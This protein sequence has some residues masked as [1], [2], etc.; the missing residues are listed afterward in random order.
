LKTLKPEDFPVST[1]NQPANNLVLPVNIDD[2]DRLLQV[3]L[4]S[5]SAKEIY[6]DHKIKPYLLD[7]EEYGT[8]T[9]EDDE[10]LSTS[11]QEND[12]S[13]IHVKSLLLKKSS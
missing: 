9:D 2:I 10:E 5:D 11:S 8:E 6:E 4:Q 7:F 1:Y 3:W 12:M 13:E